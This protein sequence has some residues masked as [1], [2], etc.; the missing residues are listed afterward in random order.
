MYCGGDPLLRQPMFPD[1]LMSSFKTTPILNHKSIHQIPHNEDIQ[2]NAV[3]TFNIL[4]SS[5]SSQFFKIKI[6]KVFQ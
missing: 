3:F 6:F 5:F 2:R 4:S 1:I